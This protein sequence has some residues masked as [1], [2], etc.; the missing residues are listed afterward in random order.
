MTTLPRIILKGLLA[1]LLATLV[2]C[3]KSTTPI[4]IGINAWPG[5][6]FIYL[7]KVKGLYQKRGIEVKI[8]SFNSLADARRAYEL[9][10]LDGLAC[11]LVEHCQILDRSER[12]PRIAMVADYS[13]GGD[14]L[15]ARDGI[16][17][18]DQLS[19]ARIGLEVESLG[20][21]ILSRLLDEASLDLESVTPVKSD[22]LSLKQLMK[23]GSIDAA[24]SYP[25]H[26]LGLLGLPGSK[27]IFSTA[28][29]PNEV[30]DIIVFDED[31]ISSRKQA[32]QEIVSAIYEAQS[33][34]RENKSVAYAIM[35]EREGISPHDFTEIVENDIHLT[36]QDEQAK[37]FEPDGLLSVALEHCDSI[38]R[39]TEQIVN[40]PR[41]EGTISTDL[42]L[43]SK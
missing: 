6:E 40:P 19:G 42:Y 18:I 37:F 9:G 35:A 23:D 24:I 30:L 26:S 32:V 29:I 25:P 15:I 33:W 31:L 3:T 41:F 2:G 5:Y 20:V 13:N 38:L 27:T 17:S 34:A 10:H 1:V 28:D 11:T 39:E 4:S 36:P 14:V 43:G 12:N 7:A 16:D 22:Q 21:F 8:V